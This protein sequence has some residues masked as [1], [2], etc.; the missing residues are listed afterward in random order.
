MKVRADEHVSPHIV[1]A[2]QDMALNE[3]WELSSVF[4]SGDRG[5]D[6]EHWITKFSH[7][8]G[9]A[10]LSADRRI[11]VHPPQIAAVFNTGMR[12]IQLPHNWA[13][14]RIALQ[15]AHVLLWWSRVEKIL[16]KMNDTE[17]YR[18]PW[19]LKETG[20]LKKIPIDFAKMQKKL[21]KANRRTDRLSIATEI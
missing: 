18:I 9:Q 17:C 20:S 15:A 6:D 11:I 8:G 14:A 13:S 2:I 12:L 3:S 1:S 10:I 7:E 5:N 19:N 16:E 21:R 4:T